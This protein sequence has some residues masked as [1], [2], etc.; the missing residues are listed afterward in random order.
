[1]TFLFEA[2]FWKAVIWTC[3]SLPLCV[4]VSIRSAALS[5][6]CTFSC[7]KLQCCVKSQWLDL[8][9]PQGTS[10]LSL[11]AMSMVNHHSF[12]G[13]VKSQVWQVECNWPAAVSPPQFSYSSEIQLVLGADSSCQAVQHSPV[14]FL[15]VAKKKQV[16]GRSPVCCVLQRIRLLT[17]Q[18]LPERSLRQLWPG[19]LCMQAGSSLMP[20]CLCQRETANGAFTGDE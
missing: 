18:I 5:K 20:A 10:F 14:L 3:H 11:Q 9:M 7:V 2:A 15:W 4:H 6:D 17:I 8:L 13:R 16:W 19:S 1:M 12:L